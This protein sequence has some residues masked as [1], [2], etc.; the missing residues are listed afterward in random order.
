MTTSVLRPKLTVHRTKFSAEFL[1]GVSKLGSAGDRVVQRR[2]RRLRDG[3]VVV[4]G[5]SVQAEHADGRLSAGVM[6]HTI[7]M[8]VED[9]GLGLNDF[10]RMLYRRQRESGMGHDQSVAVLFPEGKI[11]V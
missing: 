5:D 4:P 9:M 6:A 8:K 10:R 1:S 11:E 7:T 2:A 3:Q